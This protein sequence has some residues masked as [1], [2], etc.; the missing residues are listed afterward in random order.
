MHHR[1]QVTAVRPD[2]TVVFRAADGSGTQHE[3]PFSA[4]RAADVRPGMVMAL[5]FVT[6]SDGT[7]YATDWGYIHP[8]YYAPVMDHVEVFGANHLVPLAP[9]AAA[10]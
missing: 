7:K 9:L 8:T 10:V 5:T 4:K 2:N 6:L 1:L 3:V